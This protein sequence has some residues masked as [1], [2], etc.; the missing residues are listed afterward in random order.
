MGDAQIQKFIHNRNICFVSRLEHPL[1]SEEI[2]VS[3][4]NG[5]TKQ[6]PILKLDPLRVGEVMGSD[7]FSIGDWVLL[8]YWEN[9]PTRV[10]QVQQHFIY[11]DLQEGENSEDTMAHFYP[12]ELGYP[13]DHRFWSK[14]QK[15]CYLRC[16]FDR[17]L[18]ERWEGNTQV[19]VGTGVEW[20]VFLL[21]ILVSVIALIFSGLWM[22]YQVCHGL[23]RGMG[24]PMPT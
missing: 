13:H 1:C 10:T 12:E 2:A 4:S 6:I 7:A 8:R 24:H 11:V 21:C 15:Q 22:H 9:K 3:E 5:F 19:F 14:H 23:I 16:H 18:L 20:K 17:K